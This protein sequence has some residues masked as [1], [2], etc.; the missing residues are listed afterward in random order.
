MERHQFP[1]TFKERWKV[2]TLRVNKIV[3]M[4]DPS[5]GSVN[6]DFF[7]DKEVWI[8]WVRDL[9]GLVADWSGFEH[10][11]WSNFSEVRTMETDGLLKAD[12]H[13]F[14]VRL[15]IFFIRSFVIHLG[16]YPSPLLRPPTLTA[17]SCIDHSEKF[18]NALVTLPLPVK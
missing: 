8:S 3:E 12:F 13:K 7:Y 16:Y 17:H 10:W 9:R 4:W 6:P 11:D 15:L 2:Q 5:G 1:A 14:T 18:G